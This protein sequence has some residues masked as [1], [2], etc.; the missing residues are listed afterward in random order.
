MNYQALGR[1]LSSAFFIKIF[2]LKENGVKN[3]D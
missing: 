3:S 2:I 1:I